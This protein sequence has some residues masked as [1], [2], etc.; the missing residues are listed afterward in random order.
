[1]HLHILGIAGTFMGGIAQLAKSA[2]HQVTGAD[3]RIYPPMSLQLQAADIAFVEGFDPAQ[4][5]PVPDTV[6]VGNV[7]TRGMPIVE[8]ILNEGLNYISGPQ[9]LFENL[10]R[11]RW[12]LAVSGTHGKTSTASM[13]A[14][15][16]EYAGLSPGFLI[17]GVPENFGLSARI[18]SSPFFVIEADEYDTAFFDKRSKFIHYHP[19]TLILNN[20]EYDHAD[21]F[22]DL[23]AIQRQFH[24]LIRMVPGEGLVIH[25][26]GTHSISE[27]LEM[28]CW[29]SCETLDEQN[30]TTGWSYRADKPDCTALSI[31]YL[32]EEFGSFEWS[33]LGKHNASNAIA[34]IAAARH[35]GVPPKHSLAALAEF[36]GIK[37]RMELRGEVEGIRVYDDFAHHPT[38]IATTLAG[39]KAQQSTKQPNGGRLFAILEPRSNTMKL[40][41]HKDQLAGSVASADKAFWF[42]PADMG[43]SLAEV[44]ERCDI[45]AQVYSDLDELVT[46]VVADARPGD[47]IVCMSNGSFQGL[48]K[49]L[50][51]LVGE[52]K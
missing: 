5:K 47:W 8:A 52:Y 21:I 51:A 50:A 19:R 40:G 42:Q 28:G 3:A 4:L 7:M 29:T 1:M 25:P 9:W 26:S 34:A 17:G 27:V 15:I 38:A 48:S 14:W 39:A 37:R 12:V 44:A 2:G 24:H 30:S 13:L 22:P 31:F 11:D 20:L 49:R 33:Q 35:V 18:G 41:H 23:A 36:K 10:L 43:W 45:P 6:V 46:A 16:L 32:G